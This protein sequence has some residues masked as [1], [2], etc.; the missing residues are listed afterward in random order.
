MQED[1]KYSAKIYIIECWI[2]QNYK[3]INCYM[4]FLIIIYDIAIGIVANDAT[5]TK[6]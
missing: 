4:V 5:R 3:K 6:N 1:R 2:F